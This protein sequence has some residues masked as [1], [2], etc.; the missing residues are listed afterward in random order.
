MAS[1][2]IE[3]PLHETWQIPFVFIYGDLDPFYNAET[4]AGIASMQ[5]KMDSVEL[6]LD[7]GQG[8]VCNPD[9]AIEAIEALLVK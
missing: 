6:V 7:A 2:E 4:R 3:V 1:I 8:H 9:L 5:S